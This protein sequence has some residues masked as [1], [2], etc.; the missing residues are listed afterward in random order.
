MMRKSVQFKMCG[1]VMLLH[2]HTCCTATR[3]LNGKIAA[4]PPL[5]SCIEDIRLAMR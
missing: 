3:S 2:A 5:Y 1:E 4:A